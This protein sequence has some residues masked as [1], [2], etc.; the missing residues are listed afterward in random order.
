MSTDHPVYG[1]VLAAGLGTRMKSSKAKV[2]HEVHGKPMLLH[3]MDTIK[4]LSLDYTYV[5]VGHQREKVAELLSGY[6]AG[7]IIQAEQLGTGHAVLC[8]EKELINTGGSV[9]ILSGDVPLIRAETLQAM[10]ADHAR[11]KPV[12]TLMT[13]IMDD[14]TNYG[15]IVRSSQGRLQ[16]IVEEKD[17]SAKQKKIREINAGIYCAEIPFLFKA[18]QKIGTDNKQGEMYLTDI[19]KIAID[20]GLRVDTFTGASSEEVLGINS[21]DELARANEYL[22]QLSNE[23]QS[24]F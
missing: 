6:K 21:R 16:G 19:V 18:L 15:R 5:I 7:C 24:K 3:V 10:I 1:L 13:T 22:K 11:N 9:L 8:A 20:S 12:L 23:Q 4:K 17:A 2:L 14:P